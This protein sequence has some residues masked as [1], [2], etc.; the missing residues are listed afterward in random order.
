MLGFASFED[1][2]AEEELVLSPSPELVRPKSEENLV[3]FGFFLSK[4]VESEEEGVEGERKKA[5]TL[6]GIL[7]VT[8]VS[9]LVTGYAVSATFDEPNSDDVNQLFF[10][11]PNIDLKLLQLFCTRYC[12]VNFPRETG[13]LFMGV[14]VLN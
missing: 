7:Q 3:V 10:D 6:C 13:T 2:E 4:T 12:Y 14:V 5:A 8:L 1:I 11:H 9:R